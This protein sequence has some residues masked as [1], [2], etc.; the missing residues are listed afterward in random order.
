MRH[1]FTVYTL[2]ALAAGSFFSPACAAPAVEGYRNHEAFLDEC[3]R[4]AKSP[5]VKKKSLGTTAGGRDVILLTVGGKHADR[6]PAV[7]MLG[8]VQADSLVGSQLAMNMTAD[9]VERLKRDK[10]RT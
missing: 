2:L 5:H 9:L 1:R 10:R 4:L 7:L 8:S 6:K 3:E